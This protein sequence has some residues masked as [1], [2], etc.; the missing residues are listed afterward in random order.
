MPFCV[1]LYVPEQSKARVHKLLVRVL[2]V[3]IYYC[4]IFISI[5]SESADKQLHYF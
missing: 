3:S 1:C 5:Y 2:K 4:K